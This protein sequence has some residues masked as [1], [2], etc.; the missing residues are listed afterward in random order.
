MKYCLF[1]MVLLIFNVSFVYGDIIVK[2]N[3]AGYVTTDDILY[4]VGEVENVGDNDVKFVQIVAT[5]HDENNTVVDTDTSYTTLRVI[6][7]NTKSPFKIQINDPNQIQK[8]HNYSV[9]VSRYDEATHPIPKTLVMLSNSSYISVGGLLNIVGEIQNNGT[10]KCDFTRII[11]TYYDVNG[12]VVYV[13]STYSTPY[14]LDTD[15]KASFSL[16]V[17]NEEMNDM[18]D[19]YVLQAQSDESTMIPEFSTL[20]F[21]LMMSL[22]CIVFLMKKFTDKRAYQ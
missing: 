15:Q 7:P 20:I 10:S 13:D 4:V 5:F 17:Y 12:K 21:P 9:A 6:P 8:V 3:H 2:D 16:T 18:I 11:V 19:S 1:L 14:E 22:L